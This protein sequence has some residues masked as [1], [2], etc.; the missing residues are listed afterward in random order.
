MFLKFLT[1]VVLFLS[2]G[3][4]IHT[5][6]CRFRVEKRKQLEVIWFI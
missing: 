6:P 2:C 4:H 3:G 5:S 1:R